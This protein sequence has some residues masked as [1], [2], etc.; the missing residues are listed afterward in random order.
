MVNLTVGIHLSQ[1]KENE[2]L[3]LL[4][5][6]PDEKLA[7]WLTEFYGKTVHIASRQVLRHRDLSYVERIKIA[8]ALPESIIY[9]LVLP[10]WDVEQDLHERILIP[11]ITNSAQ[12]FLSANYGSLT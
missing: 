11:S 8:D 10:P 9:K 4:V 1:S 6:A 5:I 3:N 2:S 12:L 7:G